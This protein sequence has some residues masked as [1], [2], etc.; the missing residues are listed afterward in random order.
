MTN[1][2]FQLGARRFDLCVPT[3]AHTL[4]QTSSDNNQAAVNGGNLCVPAT[5]LK[6]RKRK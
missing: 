5:L 6:V 4:K 1:I 3:L 2:S